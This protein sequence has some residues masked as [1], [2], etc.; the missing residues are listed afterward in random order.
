M[1]YQN[2]N[3]IPIYI[4]LGVGVALVVLALWK[5]VLTI[6]ATVSAFF[7]LLLSALFTSYSGLT[8][9]AVS[10]VLSAVLGLIK[11][12]KRKEREE[13]LY[14]HVGARGIVQVLSNGLP[15]LLY[16]AVYFGTGLKP[17]LVASVVTVTAGVADSFA[18]DLGIVG[19]GRVV[20]ILTFKEVQRGMS[21]GVSLLGTFSALGVSTVLSVLLFSVGEVGI[22]G[23]WIITLSAFLGTLID[24]LLG[25]GVQRAYKC[26]ICGKMTERKSHC[27]TPTE[28]VKGLKIVDNN[29]VNA[30][31]LMVAGAI[32]LALCFII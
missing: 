9:F 18:S 16:G 14:P 28:H 30:L 8:I 10:F 29:V 21:G 24:S 1:P 17:F 11:K 19:E 12:E 25:A 7:I 26:K 3:L 5:R 20:S 27:D 2:I 32:A 23:L 13:G 31:S 6:P 15:A 4:A 22:H